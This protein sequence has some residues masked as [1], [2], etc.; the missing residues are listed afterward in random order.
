MSVKEQHCHLMVIR[1][2][3]VCVPVCQQPSAVKHNCVHVL[4]KAGLKAHLRCMIRIREAARP[5]EIR[6]A[7]QQLLRLARRGWDI[8]GR[9]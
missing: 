7:V 6:P 3:V 1:Q 5:A 8:L 2:S 9:K 4:S